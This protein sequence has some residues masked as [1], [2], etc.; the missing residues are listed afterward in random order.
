MY[1]YILFFS[2]FRFNGTT[3]FEQE[4]LQTLKYILLSGYLTNQSLNLDNIYR[5]EKLNIHPSL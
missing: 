3:L 1:G 5:F 2:V 4:I